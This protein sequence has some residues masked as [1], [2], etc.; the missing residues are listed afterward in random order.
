MTDVDPLLG[1][2]FAGRFRVAELIGSGGMATV[3]RAE[4]DVMH[5]Q[6]ALKLLHRDLLADLKIMARFQIEAR[7]A[8]RV[9][10]PNVTGVYDFGHSEEGLPYLVMEY[11]EGPTL[12]AVL[13]RE[14]PLGPARA[15]AVLVQVAEGMAAAHEAAVIHRDLKPNNIVL[16]DGDR[17]KIL[18]FGLAKIISPDAPP[19]LSTVGSTFGTP[20]YMSPEQI[21]GDRV[22]HRT[23][24]YSF[25]VLAY[26]LLAGRLPFSGALMEVLTAH[27]DEP[28]P[29][30]DGSIPPRA[31]ELV[32][33][34]LRKRA[35]DRPGRA[36]ELAAALRQIAPA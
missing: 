9:V 25:G 30:L 7:A 21:S 4:H 3:Y 19:S 31:A 1:T 12:A 11:V 34:C 36:A 35:A 22:D 5:R 8:C 6:V 26:Q 16:Q 28:P 32:L 15:L 17:V 24:I 29:P 13:E 2:L 10:H 14:G 20:E 18:D 27:L 23:D 33:D